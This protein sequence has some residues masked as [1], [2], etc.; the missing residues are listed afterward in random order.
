[1]RVLLA[2]DGSAASDRAAALVANL[3]WPTGSTIKVLTA[4]PGTAAMFSAPGMTMS[5]DIIQDTEDEMEAEARR[6]VVDVARRFATPDISV[7]TQVVRERAATAILEEA[8]PGLDLI[9]LGNR[10]RGP[11]ESAVLGSVSAEVANASHR[12]VLVARRDRI[13]RVLV[14]VDGSADAAAAVEL[15]R[16][17]SILHGT[18]VQVL[19]VAD[20]DPQWNPWLQGAAL[21]DAHLAGKASLHER[22]AAL[23]KETAQL[24]NTSFKVFSAVGYV[25][26]GLGFSEIGQGGF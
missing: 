2:V 14:G 15:V 16:R 4:Y 18:H 19:S 1:M 25:F 9:V 22:H 6:M 11:F 26:N 7:E 24:A 21:R 23:A 5:A 3:A 13:S 17:W 8:A 12:P 20:A 10:G